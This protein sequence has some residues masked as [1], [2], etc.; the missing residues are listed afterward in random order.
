MWVRK[1]R[2]FPASAPG[3]HQWHTPDDVV[4]VPTDLGFDLLAIPDA[5]FLEATPPQAAP[6]A[7]R[8]PLSEAPTQPAAP[9]SEAPT[10]AADVAQTEPD[11]A[12]AEAPRRRGRPA[13]TPN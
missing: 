8:T 3:G 11:P 5:G 10:S 12:E 9:V 4:E 7:S 2:H 13:K 1:T 6:A